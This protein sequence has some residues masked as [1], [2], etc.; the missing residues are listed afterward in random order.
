MKSFLTLALLAAIGTAKLNAPACADNCISRATSSDGCASASDFSCHCRKQGLIAA[1]QPCIA[2][3]CPYE[4]DQQAAHHAIKSACQAAG[5]K[6]SFSVPKAQPHLEARADDMAGHDMSSGAT[7]AAPKGAGAAKA[8]STT[9]GA[10]KGT[11]TSP[12]KLATSSAAGKGGKPA[13]YTGGAPGREAG[14]FLGAVFAV[15]AM[16]L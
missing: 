14:G 2:S 13:V 6:I 5:I 3:A 10:P 15:A 11:K 9:S 12:A 8:T 1:L 4:G 7:T 16:A